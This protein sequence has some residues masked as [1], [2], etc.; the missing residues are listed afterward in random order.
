VLEGNC[1]ATGIWRIVTSPAC[2]L[3]NRDAIK[4][5]SRLLLMR[6]A[7][8]IIQFIFLKVELYAIERLFFIRKWIQSYDFPAKN[9]TSGLPN[10]LYLCFTGLKCIS[11]FPSFIME[12]ITFS[13][14]IS[15]IP[16]HPEEEALQA[17]A[18]QWFLILRCVFAS[19]FLRQWT[20]S[21]ALPEPVC[22]QAVILPQVTLRMWKIK[23]LSLKESAEAGHTAF[24]GI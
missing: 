16:L 10:Y 3:K 24:G 23:L 5:I 14:G 19:L 4:K 13:I 8:I 9:K 15:S 1:L 17:F 21:V 22:T 18:F 20:D 6:P 12:S 11:I 2:R 7:D